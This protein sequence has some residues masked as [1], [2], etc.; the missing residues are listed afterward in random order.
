MRFGFWKKGKGVLTVLGSIPVE[1]RRIRQ[2]TRV[3]LEG[4]LEMVF[5]RTI[6]RELVTYS[7]IFANWVRATRI[8]GIGCEGVAATQTELFV[9]N[10]TRRVL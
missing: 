6:T 9:I 8:D 3:I 2:D 5:V 7:N 10:D 4:V 1:E